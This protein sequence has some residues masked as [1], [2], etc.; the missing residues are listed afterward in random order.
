M[1][2]SLWGR[3]ELDTTERLHFF[4]FH[5]SIPILSYCVQA[6]SALA[7][8]AGE[9]AKVG[10][11]PAFL[12]RVLGLFAQ[13]ANFVTFWQGRL[14]LSPCVSPASVLESGIS[15]RSSADSV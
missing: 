14:L 2:Y 5:V 9:E 1:G 10:L 12:P 7:T 6:V 8:G 13:C 4:L 3:K 11:A 15:A